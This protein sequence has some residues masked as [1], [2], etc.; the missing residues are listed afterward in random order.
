MQ[1]EQIPDHIDRIPLVEPAIKGAEWTYV[2]DCL[3]SGWVSSVGPY[4][5]RFERGIAAQTQSR[6]A[7]AMSSGTAALHI[8]LL[9]AGVT[10]DDEVLT[11]TLTFVASAN[12][13]RYVG[14]WPVL[15]D[16]EPNYW[17]LD[18][19]KMLNFLD[20][21]CRWEN[22]EL[23]NKTTG[24]RIKA[25]MPVHILGHPV[26]MGPI[27][28]AAQKYDLVIIEDATEAL[29]AL[30]HNEPVGHLGHIACFSF[31]GNK[32]ITTGGGGA[33]VTDNEAW[34]TRAKYLSTQAKD[35]SVEY[36]HQE[37]GYNFR[38]SNIQAAMGCA[39]LEQLAGFIDCKREIADIYA[40][41]LETVPGITL[42]H[43]ADW[44]GSIF[45]LYTVMVDERGFGM[46]SR[47][48]LERL[49][50]AGIQTR[51]LWQPLHMSPLYKD[52]PATDCRVAEKLYEQGLSL[53][54]SVQLGEG[55]ERVLQAIRTAY[56]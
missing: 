9:V 53:P 55:Q 31:N 19:Q 10:S 33:I 48:L 37:L 1:S 17:Q 41:G 26:N 34:A 21:E 6:F 5:E 27:V 38:L 36:I 24:R 28:E 56:C 2:K 43:Q 49:D 50:S 7:V 39:Q 14:A 3:D 13:I 22:R 35:D 51:P 52:M 46:S 30:Y 44:A 16:A 45:W 11:S 40:D 29:G 47:A 8:A 12:S 20:R 25:I 54:C 18:P 4:V 15:I 42:P 32:I 23:R